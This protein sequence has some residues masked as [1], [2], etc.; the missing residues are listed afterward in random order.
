MWHSGRGQGGQG[1]AMDEEFHRGPSLRRPGLVHYTLWLVCALVLLSHP[2]CQ[3]LPSR[4]SRYW[5][6][7]RANDKVTRAPS[8]PL[9]P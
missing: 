5:G 4:G 7:G 2:F 3:P 1:W 6:V 9:S 8:L